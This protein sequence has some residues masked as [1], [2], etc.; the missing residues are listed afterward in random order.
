[1][2][3]LEELIEAEQFDQDIQKEINLEYEKYI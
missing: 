2:S 3:E 1:M